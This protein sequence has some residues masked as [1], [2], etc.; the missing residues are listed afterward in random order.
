MFCVLDVRVYDIV[1]AQKK[2]EK[3]GKEHEMQ[4]Y[5]V[6]FYKIVYNC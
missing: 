6:Q 5:I 4:V 1:M 3:T 2:R